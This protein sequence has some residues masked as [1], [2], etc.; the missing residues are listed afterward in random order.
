MKRKMELKEEGRRRGEG[1]GEEKNKRTK[2]REGG[3]G[4]QRGGPGWVFQK[5][6]RERERGVSWV[7]VWV[8]RE[9]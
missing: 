2:G 1:E 3:S 4:G 7:R 9:I 6:G 8:E 5:E